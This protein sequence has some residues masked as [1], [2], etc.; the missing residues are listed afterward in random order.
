[1]LS[2]GRVWSKVC[3]N[4]VL[5]CVGVAGTC[6]GGWCGK[7]GNIGRCLHQSWTFKGRVSENAKA[8]LDFFADALCFFVDWTLFAIE[9][10]I[11]HCGSQFVPRDILWL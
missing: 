1:M 3:V 6:K 8:T 10:L 11:L 7:Q 4:V 9:Q 2:K 5:D